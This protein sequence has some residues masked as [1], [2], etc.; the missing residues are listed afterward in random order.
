MK[1]LD[2]AC[3]TF[4]AGKDDPSGHARVVDAAR[5]YAPTLEEAAANKRI[6][7]LVISLLVKVGDGSMDMPSS[8]FSA[9]LTGISIGIEMERPE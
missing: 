2:E 5:R 3:A 9:L 1:T 6:G 8:L 4:M 7:K